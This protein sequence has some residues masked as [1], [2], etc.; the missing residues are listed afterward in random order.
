MEQTLACYRQLIRGELA[1]AEVWRK[2]NVGN[3]LGVTRGQLVGNE[4]RKVFPKA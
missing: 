2:L 1:G 3:Q 4:A